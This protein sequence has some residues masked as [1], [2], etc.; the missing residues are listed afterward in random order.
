MYGIEAIATCPDRP[1]RPG[2][3][4]RRQR[5]AANPFPSFP[6]EPQSSKGAIGRLPNGSFLPEADI[7]GLAVGLVNTALGPERIS[8]GSMLRSRYATAARPHLVL[9]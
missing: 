8:R 6:G 7:G 4:E 1:A 9:D 3:Y 5:L 2:C